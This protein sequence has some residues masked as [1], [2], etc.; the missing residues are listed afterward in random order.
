MKEL[1]EIR[2]RI[3]KKKPNFF[4]QGGRL[5]YIETKLNSGSC[6]IDML[7]AWAGRADKSELDFILINRDFIC[8]PYHHS[9]TDSS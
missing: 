1:L 2:N 9:G 5:N 4:R 6:L 3:K 8:N 7:T